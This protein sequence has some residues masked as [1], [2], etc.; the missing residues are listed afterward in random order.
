MLLQE[1]EVTISL[2]AIVARFFMHGR[3]PCRYLRLKPLSDRTRTYNTSNVTD[4]EA[5]HTGCRD[6]FALRTQNIVLSQEPRPKDV[7]TSSIASLILILASGRDP[8]D[9]VDA[10]DHFVGALETPPFFLPL[11]LMS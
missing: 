2:V 6:A 11:L 3:H 7:G 5:R 10:V 4:C 9:M 1:R 8:R